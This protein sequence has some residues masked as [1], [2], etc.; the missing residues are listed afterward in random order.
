[1][2][3]LAFASSIMIL[4]QLFQCNTVLVGVVGKGEIETL[5]EEYGEK[6]SQTNFL[7][8]FHP[9]NLELLEQKL[10]FEE[11][12]KKSIEKDIAS[13]EEKS[14][15][16]PH[17][18]FVLTDRQAALLTY[19]SM[20]F[21]GYYEKFQ[22]Y[23][24]SCS[25]MSLETLDDDI[26]FL[27]TV[28]LFRSLQLELNN[29]QKSNH[30]SSGS[31]N[32]EIFIKLFRKKVEEYEFNIGEC[33]FKHPSKKAAAKLSTSLSNIQVTEWKIRRQ[34]IH[35]D[36]A[37]FTMIDTVENF[38]QN[39]VKVCKVKP[40]KEESQQND[41]EPF[42]EGMIKSINL[43]NYLSS[44]ISLKKPMEQEDEFFGVL[45]VLL[46]WIRIFNGEEDDF[47]Y[48]LDIL[49]LDI[50]ESISETLD[51]YKEKY[52]EKINEILATNEEIFEAKESKL[53]EFHSDFIDYMNGIGSF[54]ENEDKDLEGM[55]KLILE[56]SPIL[57]RAVAK[58]NPGIT[59]RPTTR[60]YFVYSML[61]KKINTFI[62]DEYKVYREQMTE[63]YGKESIKE[64][65][66]IISEAFQDFFIFYPLLKLQS[67]D[68]I[69]KEIIQY[70]ISKTER[71]DFKDKT[72]SELEI[73]RE[74]ASAYKKALVLH[75]PSIHEKDMICFSVTEP[76]EDLILSLLNF[77]FSKEVIDLK[78][79][80]SY[81]PLEVSKSIFAIHTILDKD[82]FKCKLIFHQREEMT[83]QEKQ[84]EIE[85]CML[86][87]ELI[88]KFRCTKCDEQSSEIWYRNEDPK[89]EHEKDILI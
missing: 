76:N 29:K 14:E 81:R 80:G 54:K 41:I 65:L 25:T 5:L 84:K 42:R 74:I 88:I 72:K 46:T 58:M 48:C 13:S 26:A 24:E 71:I 12:Q 27:S 18:F 45:S 59:E 6:D 32:A 73:Q 69:E 53:N 19:E 77:P 38:Y 16:P 4:I 85:R 61:G 50:F 62:S 31:Q 49:E 78:N 3:K 17:F 11:K 39:Y 8:M 2:A 68:F 66:E 43:V 40:E 36:L 23:L 47:D 15:F 9:K 21:D 86:T 35:I 28:V 82:K 56:S 51:S 75:I 10:E 33:H 20:K 70:Y 52:Q 30:D 87:I 60:N 67:K 79:K 22:E 63:V 37:S 83:N 89:E 64:F 57:I 55:K 7:Y 34:F 1:M 44:Q